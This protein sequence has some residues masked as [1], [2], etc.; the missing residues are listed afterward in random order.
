MDKKI[1]EEIINLKQK[2]ES[3]CLV[4]RANSTETK[5]VTQK[6]NDSILAES[7]K[8]AIKEDKL[9]HWSSV[10]EDDKSLYVSDGTSHPWYAKTRSA[11]VRHDP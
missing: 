5:I 8:K 9:S 7:I 1:L 6:N 2:K 11:L 3:F 10:N 4:S